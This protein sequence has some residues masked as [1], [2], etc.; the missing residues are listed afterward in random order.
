MWRQRQQDDAF[1]PF[2]LDCQQAHRVWPALK[3]SCSV[4]EVTASAAR[5]CTLQRISFTR[6]RKS[7]RAAVFSDTGILGRSD[8]RRV[9][10]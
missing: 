9:N 10:R 8:E 3:R 6:W 1:L 4:K 7:R 5:G 2:A